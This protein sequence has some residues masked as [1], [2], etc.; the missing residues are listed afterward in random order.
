MFPW[1]RCVWSTGT[2]WTHQRTSRCPPHS[3][4]SSVNAPS[5]CSDW[6]GDWSC[7]A[8]PS[9]CRAQRTSSTLPHGTSRYYTDGLQAPNSYRQDS[10]REYP[11]TLT[12]LGWGIA[13]LCF[14]VITSK[15]FCTKD[16]TSH[17]TLYQICDVPAPT[18]VDFPDTSEWHALG[19]DYRWTQAAG[20]HHEISIFLHLNKVSN[21]LI[22]WIHVAKLHFF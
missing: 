16:Y 17:L 13:I 14:S 6:S 12:S 15:T 22:L 5:G 7:P 8:D 1:Q 2:V 19:L 18:A 3:G 21:N 4:R 9:C 20:L 11:L 10:Q